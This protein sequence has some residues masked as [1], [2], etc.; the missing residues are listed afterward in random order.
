MGLLSFVTE[1]FSP[2]KELIDELHYSG[3]EKAALKQKI[4]EA[5]IAMSAKV[6]DYETRK[7]ELQA[8]IIKVEGTG[9]SWLQRNWRPM[10][11]VTVASILANNY[12][13]VPWLHAVGASGAPILELPVGLWNLL[14]V[15]VGGYIVGRTAEKTSDKWSINIGGNKLEKE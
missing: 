14:T 9:E 6:L 1:I 4:F 5:E 3:E 10:L 13:L 11:M 2:A 12:V 8:E 15:G 7:M